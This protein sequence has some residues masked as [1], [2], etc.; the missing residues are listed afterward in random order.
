M[1]W[2]DESLDLGY[3]MKGDVLVMN[4]LQESIGNKKLLR[5]SEVYDE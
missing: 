2:L 5:K 1:W 3:N 4:V